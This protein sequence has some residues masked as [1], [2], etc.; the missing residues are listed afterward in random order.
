MNV[1]IKIRLWLSLGL[2]I[3]VMMSCSSKEESKKEDSKENE[4]DAIFVA[5]TFLKNIVNGNFKSAEE[6]VTKGSYSS[7]K[8]LDKSYLYYQS[9]N[10]VSVK[11][12]EIEGAEAICDCEFNY[13]NED[14]FVKQLHLQKFDDEW[15]VDFQ[16]DVNF[17]NIFVYDYSY[18]KESFM[19]NV[20]QLEFNDDQV[21]LI[22]NELNILTNGYVK[23]GFS[24]YSVVGMIDSLLVGSSSY[25]SSDYETFDLVISNS[26]DFDTELTYCNADVDNLEDMTDM[27]QYFRHMTE[28]VVEKLGMPFNIPKDKLD[29]MYMYGQLRWFI[30]SY[31]EIL[32]LSN[33]DGYYNLELL[34]IP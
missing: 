11:S 9:I 17:D 5:Q 1:M 13:Y 7:L 12:C 33:Y 4:E 25:G 34:D 28:L 18:H 10:L 26:Y 8:K 30:K 2:F 14:A 16:L 22:R 29:E 3:G 27:N 32:V 20:E 24:E 15:L 23:I 6:F 21:A 19:N 31:N